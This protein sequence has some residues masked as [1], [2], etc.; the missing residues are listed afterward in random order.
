MARLFSQCLP[1]RGGPTIV[2]VGPLKQLQALLLCGE[3]FFLLLL[4]KT[5]LASSAETIFLQ[6]VSFTSSNTTKAGSF[7]LQHPSSPR[8]LN[9]GAPRIV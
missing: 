2:D 8:V 1:K 6:F 4:N 9:L 5:I 3:P 7:E